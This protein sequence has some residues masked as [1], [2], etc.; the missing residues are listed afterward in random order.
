MIKRKNNTTQVQDG[1][2]QEIEKCQFLVDKNLVP[3]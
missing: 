3:E 2:H 1:I